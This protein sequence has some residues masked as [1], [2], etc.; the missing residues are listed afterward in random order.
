MEQ[1]V[2]RDGKIYYGSVE[3]LN[4]DDAYR[5]FRDDYNVALGKRYYQ[6][7]G[8]LG[9]RKER[10]HGFG[11]VYDG[12]PDLPG[13]TGGLVPTRLLG[14][15]AGAYCRMLGSWDIPGGMDEDE[16]WL[17]F[18]WAFRKNGGAVRLV[19]RKDKAG[20]TSK[21]LSKRFK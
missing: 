21:I 20:R 5:K 4:A 19:G 7:L 17:W 10:V 6:R 13:V 9:A 14:I 18:Q 3:C 16:F 12:E 15:A 8:R 1:I 2:K 11:F